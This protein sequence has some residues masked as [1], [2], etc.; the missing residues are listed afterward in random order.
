M[1]TIAV[2][3]KS[4]LVHTVIGTSAN[5]DVTQAGVLLHVN[6]ANGDS[7]AACCT[8]AMNAQGPRWHVATQQGGRR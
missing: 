4:G 1:A 3:A 8:N 7:A 5:N 6:D 2:D